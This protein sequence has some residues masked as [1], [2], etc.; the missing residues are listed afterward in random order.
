ML[1]VYVVDASAEGRNKI[2]NIIDDLL[3]A[4]PQSDSYLPP[5]SVKPLS[6]QEIKFHESPDICIVGEEILSEDISELGKIKKT[7]PTA[8]HI[9]FVSKLQNNL[10]DIETLARMGA[11]DVLDLE[12]APRDL[13]KKIV[14][15][16][17]K[18]SRDKTGRLVLV[19]SGKGGLGVTTIVAAIGEALSS[20][21]QRV[22]LV[23]FDFETQDLSRFLHARPYANENLQSLLTKN[24]PITQEFVEQCLV[25]IWEDHDNFFHLSPPPDS[26]ILYDT[27]SATFRSMLFI[28]EILDKSFDCLIIDLAC[29]RGALRRAL[30]RAADD[31]VFIINNDP[32]SLYA[33]VDQISRASAW[34]A[35][36]A[37]LKVVENSSS[38]FGLGSKLLRK[39]FARAAKLEESQFFDSPIPFC[40]QAHR[41]PGSGASA[42]SQGKEKIRRAI[43]ELLSDLKLVD[44]SRTISSA[45]KVAAAFKNLHMKFKKQNKKTSEFTLAEV[46]KV[47]LPSGGE[48]QIEDASDLNGITAIDR[49]GSAKLAEGSEK[50]LDELTPE[51][52]ISGVN[53]N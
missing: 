34:M 49:N 6:R 21:D 19:D 33:S 10:A 14:L 35:P 15:L 30:Y 48:S 12:V 47:G 29:L 43:D 18:A 25:K 40:K 53:F 5:I 13:L 37:K 42:F 39:E 22:L 3:Q 44:E 45:E 50:I 36:G 23:D 8:S 28:L 38:A 51:K 1:K 2:L 41:W 31:V 24:R 16:A 26:E 52:L 20:Y 7:F 4:R 32:A 46:D 27:R 17:R 9:A 11:D